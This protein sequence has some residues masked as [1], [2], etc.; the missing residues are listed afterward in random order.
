MRSY[1][2]ADF[3]HDVPP[4]LRSCAGRDWGRDGGRA[5]GR[6]GE[7]R[8]GVR[9][10][11]GLRG[12]SSRMTVSMQQALAFGYC[13]MISLFDPILHLIELGIANG[14]PG[15]MHDFFHVTEKPIP[16]G[17]VIEITEIRLQLF[18]IF[19]GL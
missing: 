17:A 10:P 11:V 19:T 4:W 18:R 14:A 1:Q 9:E 3:S 12:R 2:S 5:C 15:S 13:G 8:E 16:A 7:K 6:W